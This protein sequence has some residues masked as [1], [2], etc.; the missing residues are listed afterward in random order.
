MDNIQKA[1]VVSNIIKLFQENNCTY[2][3]V[4][5]INTAFIIDILVGHNI[6]DNEMQ[7]LLDHI[8]KEVH[9]NRHLYQG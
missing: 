8:K 6:P 2:K 9:E 4:L 5:T 1:S 7:E 3:E